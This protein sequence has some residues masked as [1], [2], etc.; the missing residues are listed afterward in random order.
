MMRGGRKW[1]G[2]EISNIGG[3]RRQEGHWM[4][5][6]YWYIQNNEET[7]KPPPIRM[8]HPHRFELEGS[9]VMK[10]VEHRVVAVVGTC[11][12]CFR[13]HDADDS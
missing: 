10:E 8:R 2:E 12:G 4:V 9:S 6:N 13:R 1:F 3:N 5:I 7:N 11:R